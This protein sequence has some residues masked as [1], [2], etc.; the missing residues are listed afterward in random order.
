MSIESEMPFSHLILCCPLFLL[1][2]IPPSIRVFSSELTLKSSQ[3]VQLLSRVQLFAIPWTAACQ[4]SLCI[5]NSLSLL[6]LISIKLV[7]P[8]NHLILCQP[9]SSSHL[10]SFPASGSFQMSQ[11]FTS[12]GLSIGAS[13]SASVLPINIQV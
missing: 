7:M 2:P 12:G 10:Q 6:M 11:L 1:P 5:I 4:A 9:P 3:S 8:S 13:A